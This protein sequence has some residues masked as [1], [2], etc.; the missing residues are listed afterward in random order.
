MNASNR[1]YTAW[2]Y[3]D[4]SEREVFD[5]IEQLDI[6]ALH[7]WPSV[8]FGTLRETDLFM[9]HTELGPFVA[10]IKSH[11]I[12]KIISFGYHEWEIKLN[13]RGQSPMKQAE[14]CVVQ[15]REVL[16]DNRVHGLFITP[17]VL[18]SSIDRGEWLAK[19]H[20]N[21]RATAMADEMIFRDECLQSGA[22]FEAALLRIRL[23]RA[24]TSD[25][26]PKRVPDAIIKTLIDVLGDPKPPVL[27]NID[28]RRLEYFEHTYGKQAQRHL[29][30]GSGKRI[31]LHGAPGTGKTWALLAIA[32]QHA[33]AG[34]RVL[35]LCYNRVLRSDV[36]RMV[37]GMNNR[38]LT[39]NL[40]ICTI[41]DY[42]NRFS[43]HVG[44]DIDLNENVFDDWA[45]L[46]AGE[47]ASYSDD[48]DRF[49]V[50]LVDEAQD[51]LDY[52]EPVLKNCITEAASIVIGVGV[53][54]ELYN[55]KANVSWLSRYP[56]EKQPIICQNVYRSPAKSFVV[57]Q[58]MRESGIKQRRITPNV[59]DIAVGRCMNPNV[60]V[61]LRDAYGTGP[62]FHK[63]SFPK[64]GKN[65]ADHYVRLLTQF[66]K[67]RRTSFRSGETLSDILFLIPS[68][69]SEYVEWLTE[70]LNRCNIK[71]YN[72]L[73][74]ATRDSVA[75][76]DQVRICTYHSA[77]GIEAQIV[78]LLDLNYLDG[79]E[80]TLGPIENLLY[81]A[82]TRSLRETYIIEKDQEESVS[83]KML[84]QI[85]TEVNR[86][87]SSKVGKHWYEKA[88]MDEI[89]EWVE[90]RYGTAPTTSASAVTANDVEDSDDDT[91]ELPVETEASADV[92]VTEMETSEATAP[93]E[94][95]WDLRAWLLRWIEPVSKHWMRGSN[96]EEMENTN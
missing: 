18:W 81:I 95:K 70:S 91:A 83:G 11:T 52:V 72:Y 32:R 37:R 78:I 53:G 86:L 50:I 67:N 27:S 4:E 73:D 71:S 15:I 23:K 60:S 14:D 10:E 39:D 82:L 28:R 93:T 84:E 47:I 79:A 26:A 51:M 46:V 6:Q 85:T 5:Q 7:L 80:T 58:A 33:E 57:A 44:L 77:R 1:T 49:D 69:K 40:T 35:F 68:R 43:Q 92:S 61:T 3:S 34:K 12:D 55:K 31:S 74:D 66:I 89:K 45:E 21:S 88:N 2:T 56:G 65:S 20:G 41:F 9:V 16:R 62:V 22:T 8:H 94:S 25:A 36:S 29:P 19:F 96:P 54:Q 17:T 64:S 75:A 59:E 87:F 38:S 30:V 90:E 63:L 76:D 13:G 42:L 48:Q 24:K